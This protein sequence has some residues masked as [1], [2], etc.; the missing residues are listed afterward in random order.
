ML[1]R[2]DVIWKNLSRPLYHVQF[3]VINTNSRHKVIEVVVAAVMV[4]VMVSS[5]AETAAVVAVA[6]V[7]NQFGSKSINF[8][9]WK[10][11]FKCRQQSDGRHH[12][13]HC[14]WRR[15]FIIIIVI[16]IIAIIFIMQHLVTKQNMIQ[17][18]YNQTGTLLPENHILKYPNPVKQ[19]TD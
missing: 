4:V 18:Y 8:L 13:R 17:R 3:T 7:T 2:P 19:A 14:R 11:I 12:H 15:Y 10:C 16:I 6:V 5:S 9:L 1:I